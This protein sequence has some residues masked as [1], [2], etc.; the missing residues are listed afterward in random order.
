MDFKITDLAAI[1]LASAK[2]KR[3]LLLKLSLC[4]PKDTCDPPVTRPC[5]P[6]SCLPTTP[7]PTT[8]GGASTDEAPCPGCDAGIR[9][10]D[11]VAE[12]MEEITRLQGTKPKRP[13]KPKKKAATKRPKKR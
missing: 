2:A 11:A 3:C 13:P 12:L 9:I 4:P 6:G 5:C 10:Y 1:A 8:C 7:V